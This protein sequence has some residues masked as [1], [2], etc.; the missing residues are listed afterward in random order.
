[1]HAVN[2]YS[3]FSYDHYNAKSAILQIQG[4]HSYCL[5]DVWKLIESNILKNYKE[6]LRKAVIFYHVLTSDEIN[7]NFDLVAANK[8]NQHSILRE[9]VPVLKKGTV[10]ILEVALDVVSGFVNELMVMTDE[11]LAFIQKFRNGEY[12]P[13]LLFDDPEIIDR[14]SWHPMARWKVSKLKE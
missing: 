6:Q 1:M 13:E 3:S 9:L 5:Y 12:C 11:E 10:F 4:S 2:A 14:I 8:L 7:G